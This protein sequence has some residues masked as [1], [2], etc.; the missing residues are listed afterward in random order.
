MSTFISNIPVPPRV[1]TEDEQ[2]ALLKITGEHVHGFRDHMVF[3]IALGTGLREHEIAALQVGDIC[4]SNQKVRRRVFLNTF[5][6]CCERPANQEILISESLRTKLTKYVDWKRKR[7]ESLE[8][9][10]FL[11]ISRKQNQISTRQI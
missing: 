2:N 3:S 8:A 6:K 4:D 1:M 10:A 11:F 7:G 9:T 5:K